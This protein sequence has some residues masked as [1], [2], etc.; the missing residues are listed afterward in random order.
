MNDV[1][2]IPCFACLLNKTV[3]PYYCNP[4]NC[5]KL[6]TWLFDIGSES[7]EEKEEDETII[8]RRW[9]SKE[10]DLLWKRMTEVKTGNIK[11]RMEQIAKELGRTEQAV[12]LKYCQLKQKRKGENDDVFEQEPPQQQAPT[13]IE[14]VERLMFVR[15]VGYCVRLPENLCQ[16]LNLK[17]KDFL[18]IQA[19]ENGLKVIPADVT[20]RKR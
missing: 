3:N 20:P 13:E 6:G 1:F 18:I 14:V 4:S 8:R 15:G 19:N 2:S 10:E 12:Y 16:N 17:E 5:V 7:M 9:D 11:E